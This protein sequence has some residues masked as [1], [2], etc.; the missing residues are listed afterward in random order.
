MTLGVI[1]A[2]SIGMCIGMIGL[3]LAYLKGGY[4]Y[5]QTVDELPKQDIQE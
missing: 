3:S 2:I 1:M 5:K 4:S